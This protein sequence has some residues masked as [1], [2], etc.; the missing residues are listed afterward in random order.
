MNILP[1]Y[2]LL[3][4]SFLFFHVV[5]HA[6]TSQGQEPIICKSTLIRNIHDIENLRNCTIIAGH[7][8]L[9]EFELTPQTLVTLR[10]LKLEE[11][12]DYLLVYRVHGLDSLER[13]FPKLLVIRGV[14]LL[15]EKY[16]LVV[17]E[18]RHMENIGLISLLRVL[19]GSI[20]IESNPS[21]CYT[22]TI[23]WA[24]I[25]GN[26]TKEFHYVIKN[27]KP[28]NYCPLCYGI[29][30]TAEE[31]HQQCW[32]LGKPQKQV[33][34]EYDGNQCTAACPSQKCN[35]KGKCCS[36]NCLTSCF[37]D[38]CRYCST[39]ISGK[40][41]V[42]DCLP[43]KARAFGRQ[44]VAD[45]TQYGLVKLGVHCLEKCP[46]M[47]ETIVENGK[48]TSCSLSCRGNF[49]IKS[50]EDLE[51]FADCTTLQG[52]L[53]LELT[54]YNKTNIED[55]EK[56]FGN[57]SE[58]TGY[59]KIKRSPHIVS[60]HFFRSLHTIGG[61]ILIDN[62]YALYVV[63]NDYLEDLWN[64]NQ[65]V[66]ITKGRIFFH[67]NPRLCYKKIAQLREQIKESNQIS[68]A[69]VSMNSN[70]ELVVCD[71][72]L[73]E[74]N[75]TTEAVNAHEALI[76]IDLLP[77]DA[78]QP[79][80]GYVYFYR[81][82]PKRNISKY[83]SRHGCGQDNW[84][85]DTTNSTQRRHILRNLKPNTQYAYFVKTLTIVNYH[86][87]IDA[88]SDIQYFR[89]ALAKP[90]PLA[91]I[92]YRP[93]SPNEI[94][95]HWWPP[96]T[97]NG[98]INKYLLKYDVADGNHTAIPIINKPFA[99]FDNCRCPKLDPQLSGPLP[100]DTDYYNEVQMTYGASLYNFIFVPDKNKTT[101]VETQ[102]EAVDNFQRIHEEMFNKSVQEQDYRK[103]DFEIATLPDICNTT[104]RPTISYK[105]E[106]NCVEREEFKSDY[107]ISGDTHFFILKGL[108]P[109]TMY[110]ISLRACVKDLANGC[111]PETILWAETVSK[112]LGQILENLKL[113]PPASVG[114]AS[115]SNK[116]FV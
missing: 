50:A 59:L 49:T 45:C 36:G 55:L 76:V 23:N 109:H 51:G 86:Y 12:T 18:N 95:I 56:A 106:N 26:R 64:T 13:I 28:P 4:T 96:R 29:N 35:K 78:L 14:R 61:Q 108:Q 104:T 19:R 99:N 82:A 98:I 111:G 103:E 66:Q 10:P 107:E 40:K 37:D 71:S 65:R 17:V 2:F 48:A 1:V 27:N 70:G 102:N 74:L 32:S 8:K 93:L 110:R 116:L 21:L 101:A 105:K 63:G 52:S 69:D 39:L 44:C 33:M 60:L 25:L 79:L 47:Y 80:I 91:K 68:I 9:V 46:K 84:Y 85:M 5:P 7:I 31:R 83:D 73:H 75:V 20:R 3:V 81:E 16:G 57:L 15:Y 88:S 113:T 67:L 22:H 92:Y 42:R 115:V 53:T 54:D 94:E 62:V 90:G 87:L 43:P 34:A 38:N 77:P 11:I 114:V 89:T 100:V 112:S 6:A 97:P 58:I 30:P 41:C 72:E 24:S